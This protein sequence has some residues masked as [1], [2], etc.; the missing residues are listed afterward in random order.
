[1]ARKGSISRPLDLA[2]ARWEREADG[3][4]QSGLALDPDPT[5]MRLDDPL[6]DEE[7]E[8]GA[9]ARARARRPVS[10]EHVGP[11]VL[12]DARPG[13]GDRERREPFAAFRAH[14]DARS[15]SAELDRVRQDIREDL[16]DPGTIALHRDGAGRPLLDGDALLQ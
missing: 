10:L 15:R 6:A 13:V 5:T 14:A 9:V 1:M 2:G 11:I 8:P 16:Q 7:A 12:R 3:R 4:P